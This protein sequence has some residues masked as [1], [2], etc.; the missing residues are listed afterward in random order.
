M[1]WNYPDGCTQADVDAAFGAVDLHQGI[2]VID[3][4]RIRLEF[5]HPPIP[6]RSS[7]WSAVDDDTYDVD[8]DEGGYFSHCPIGRGA[9]AEEALADLLEQL[10]EATQ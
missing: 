8:C 2:N 6:D 3:G 5:E 1:S 4:R 10:E 9:T 7:D